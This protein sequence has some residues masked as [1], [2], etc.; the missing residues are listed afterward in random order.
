MMNIFYLNNPI[1]LLLAL[2]MAA[3][4][5][6]WKMPSRN[7][8]ILR[9][10]ILVLLILAMSQLALL[11]PSRAGTVI[12]VADRSLSM[13]ADSSDRLKEAYDLL[14]DQ[15]SPRDQIGVVSFADTVVTEKLPE[16][17]DFGGFVAELNS[18]GSN[19]NQAIQKALSLIPENRHGRILLLTDGKWTG[20]N[21]SQAA[22]QA[23]AT[24]TPIDYRLMQ[25]TTANDIAVTHIDA[26]QTVNPG[27]GFLVTAW[28][29]SPISQEISYEFSRQGSVL[30]MGTKSVPSGLSSVTFRDRADQA[31][32]QQYTFRI[33]QLETQIILD[34]TEPVDQ[35]ATAAD[36]QNATSD[37][38]TATENPN[39]TV[40]LE[41]DPVPENNQA[42]LLIGVEGPR[43]ILCV[44][45]SA[46]SGLA[47]LI[48]GGGVQVVTAGPLE[49]NW[50]LE[51]MAKYS[52]VLIEDVL[53][54]DIGLTGME[55]IAVYVK[56]AG[57]GLMMT[58]G[59]NSYGPGGYFRS[60]LEPVM[61]ISMELRREH[62]KLSLAIVVALDRSGS[63][64]ASVG[65][66]K[67]KMDLANLASVQVLDMLTPMDEMGVVAVDS[68]AH[69][70]ARVRQVGE[71]T[72][73]RQDILQIHSMGGGIFVYTALMKATQMI[74]EATS[75]TKHIILFADAADAEEPDKY[76]ELLAYNQNAN[77]T[78]SVIGLGSPTDVDAD[79]LRDVALRGNGRCFFTNNPEELPRLFA[80]DTFVVARSSFIEEPTPIRITGGMVSLSQTSYSDPPAVG[81]YNL[82]YIRENAN[83]AVL[84]VDEY[85]APIVSSW[86]AGMGRVLCYT[87]Q[88]DGE[89]AGPITEWEDVGEFYTSLA[90]WTAGVSETL[91]ENIVIQQTVENGVCYV[92]A[93]LDPQREAEPFTELPT[94]NILKGV[95]GQK[96][97][98]AQQPMQWTNADMLQL[99]IPLTGNETSISTVEIAGIGKKTLAPVCLVYSPE[100]TPA[101]NEQAETNIKKLTRITGG[102][103]R[104]ELGNIWQDIPRQG[105][106]IEISHWLVI[107]AIILFL[108]EI[109]ERR[110]GL[111]SVGLEKEK[112]LNEEEISIRRKK[113]IASAQTP[114]EKTVSIRQ[115]RRKIQRKLTPVQLSDRQPKDTPP[116]DQ[117]PPEK[118]APTTTESEPSD[119]LDALQ[120]FRKNKDN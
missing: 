41:V 48:R 32:V 55:N 22:V 91:D 46:N 120:K 80:Q 108:V 44:T 79:F 2:P 102:V 45:N 64:A 5:M 111:L 119:V 49:C 56:Q 100:F 113:Q 53:A 21:P 24:N 47:A 29:Q 23:T 37:Q 109:L 88:A 72:K 54:N 33:K 19:L 89:F 27:E 92:R 4:L 31:G 99:E 106:L 67:S 95:P 101:D 16:T 3:V 98:A 7:M 17:T 116:P 69:I 26:P 43:P 18:N 42:K 90:R 76:R 84:S 57:A 14:Q 81:G 71:N 1:W 62:R 28:I 78:T 104:F 105:R 60:P 40:A 58:G 13:P 35:A 96:A 12:V 15:M 94:V 8:L 103:E 87:G 93:Y 70:I 50:S 61:P 39:Q 112:E 25:R 11:L 59:Q 82:C 118:P 115:I 20:G 83:P 36:Q 73:L 63:M 107:L 75:G 38:A 6:I 77:I 10:S 51:E 110:T 85:N 66:G 34:P 9:I 74:Q 52:A 114:A 65:G 68:A 86:I 117:S 97:T 30:A